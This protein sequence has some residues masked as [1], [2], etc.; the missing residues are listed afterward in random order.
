MRENAVSASKGG[1]NETI[2]LKT[3]EV[4][5]IEGICLAVWAMSA[6]TPIHTGRI[7]LQ[8]VTEFKVETSSSLVLYEEQHRCW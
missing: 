6:L 2:G 7:P 3:T 8:V 4:A 1:G 5:S